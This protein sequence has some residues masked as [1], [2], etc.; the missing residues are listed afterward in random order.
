MNGDIL[1]NIDY[2]KLIDFHTQQ[3]CAATLAIREYEV[4]IAYGVVE[5]DNY[6]V[7]GIKEKPVHRF[8][9]NAGI[10]V[11][12]NSC[13]SFIP[14]DSYFEMTTLLE[15]LIKNNFKVKAFPIDDYW[16]DIGKA[17]DY[18]E[19]NIEYPALGLQ[20]SSQTRIQNRT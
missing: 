6:V 11:L 9:I 16:I 19:A 20:I 10:Y 14:P 13:L 18:A 8:L 15:A 4:G 3:N 12:D 2:N 7:S 1:T 5:H 17:D